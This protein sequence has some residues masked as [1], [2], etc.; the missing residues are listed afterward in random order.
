MD[1]KSGDVFCAYNTY[2]KKYT[3]C[4]V[5]KIEDDDD[6][7]PKAVLLSLDWSDDRPLTEEQLPALKPLYKDF[8]YWNRG[9]HLLNV[10]MQVP[11]THTLVGNMNPLSNESTNSYGYWGEGYD[12]YRQLQWQQIPQ[13]QRDAFK[14]A[15]KS[16][17]KITLAGK[18][19]PV[20]RHRIDD[21]IPFEDAGELMALPCL[22]TLAYWLI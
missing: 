9:L 1:A 18:E 11:L 8:V 6:K 4:Q 21:D 13:E 16:E 7:K 19:V 3:A 20:S 17:E 2:L 12:V 5:T 15:E 10:D 22:S 14:A